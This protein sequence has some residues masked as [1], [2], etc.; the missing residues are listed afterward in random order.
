MTKITNTPAKKHGYLPTK[1]KNKSNQ[2]V[3]KNSKNKTYIS[4]DVGSNDGN[5]PHNGGVWKMAKSP[6]KLNSK[7]TR[8]GTYDA[9]LKRIGD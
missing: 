5:G 7:N 8:M 6:G 4:Q 9:N 3:F 1:E 2:K